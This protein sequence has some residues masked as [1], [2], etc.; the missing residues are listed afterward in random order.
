[1]AL[2]K[3]VVTEG[4]LRVLCPRIGPLRT[5]P[6]QLARRARFWRDNVV[7]IGAKRSVMRG[8]ICSPPLT[9]SH[10]SGTAWR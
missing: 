3:V 1:M 5:V 9:G 10:G 7:A 8:R 4:K 2:G 6:F